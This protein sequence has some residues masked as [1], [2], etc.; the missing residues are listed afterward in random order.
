MS[1]IGVRLNRR[2]LRRHRG[3][4]PQVWVPELLKKFG[5]RVA[6]GPIEA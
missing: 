6:G 4:A 5:G 1:E 3:R 2:E